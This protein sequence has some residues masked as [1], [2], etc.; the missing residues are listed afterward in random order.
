MAA[1]PAPTTD[2]H[3]PVPTAPSGAPQTPVQSEVSRILARWLDDWLRIPGTNFRIGLDPI[4]S[5]FPGVGDFFTSSAGLVILLE[6][7]RN[8]VSVFV[9]MRMGFNMLLNAL[10]N[11]VPGLGTVGSA[12]FKSNSRNLALLKRWQEG[13]AH[14]VRRSSRLL[15]VVLAFIFL[16]ILAVWIGVLW[17]YFDLLM[18]FYHG[19]VSSLHPSAS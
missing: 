14:E 8:R 2:G 13:H 19:I 1:D 15:V 10:M 12:L 16:A 11:L 3:L 7:V 5:I 6:A 18:S 17:I 9:L 4:I